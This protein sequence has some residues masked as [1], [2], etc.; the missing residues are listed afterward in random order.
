[1][2]NDIIGGILEKETPEVKGTNA[3]SDMHPEYKQLAGDSVDTLIAFRWMGLFEKVKCL[4]ACQTSKEIN[5]PHL[6]KVQRSGAWH[7]GKLYV[8]S[9]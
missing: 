5:H 3:Y 6:G 4:H 8:I 1:M 2:Q 9:C 7:S